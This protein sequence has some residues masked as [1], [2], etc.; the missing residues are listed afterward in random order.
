MWW[1][2]IFC[3]PHALGGPGSWASLRTRLPVRGGFVNYSHQSWEICPQN[4]WI[5]PAVW[6]VLIPNS[7]SC[8]HLVTNCS[9]VKLRKESNCSL[10]KHRRNV[11]GDRP[12]LSCFLKFSPAW[13]ETWERTSRCSWFYKKEGMKRRFQNT[14]VRLSDWVH[15]K[16]PITNKISSFPVLNTF[17]IW[18]E[19]R[20]IH[21]LTFV[22]L[23][24][25]I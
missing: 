20:N 2:Q 22:F 15:E 14:A 24:I 18:I 8:L 25:L 19:D 3:F 5:A 23:P 10:V 11:K 12:I 6:Q 9:T 4:L 17:S 16:D 13:K 1:P 7:G 21:F